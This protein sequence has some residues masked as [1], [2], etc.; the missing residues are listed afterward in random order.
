MAYI[1]SICKTLGNRNSDWETQLLIVQRLHL[2]ESTWSEWHSPKTLGLPEQIRLLRVLPPL[3]SI[4]G[5]LDLGVA[6]LEAFH[7]AC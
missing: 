4:S 5:T 6:T 7:L 2:P 3:I 1:L